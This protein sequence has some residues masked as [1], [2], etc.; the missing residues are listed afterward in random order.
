M[1]PS[2]FA[3]E[4]AASVK[5]ALELWRA[6]GGSAKWLAGGHSLLPLMKLRLSAPP[7]L[8][9]ISGIDELRGVA[10]VGDRVVIGAL[11]THRE[12]ATHPLIRETLPALSD[13]AR[14][15]GDLQV[16]NRGT[17][18]G[19]LAHADTASDLPAVAVS[20]GAELLVAT[21]DGDVVLPAQEFFL[22]PLV[23]AM[24]ENGLLKAVS[25]PVPPGNARGVYEKFPHPASGYA[26]VGVAVT[27]GVDAQGV[28]D[29]V[30]VGVTGA[31]DAAY[32]AQA[33]EEALLGREPTPD[34]LRAAAAKAA[35]DGAIAG[36][37]F[38]SE[39]YRRH[40]CTVV[41]ER[42]LRRALG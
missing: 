24:P 11:T 35:D 9:D 39:A 28:V 29:F 18:G 19:N 16:R 37:A 13:A 2:A 20:L 8:I 12:L 23:T 42:A 31:A 15:V 26:V 3:Y 34:A 27:A 6:S 22:G 17:I 32:R 40:L 25:F 1:I 38:A 5:E 7:K 14:Q 33:V 21:P 41:A 30:R 4:R 36:D 10:R